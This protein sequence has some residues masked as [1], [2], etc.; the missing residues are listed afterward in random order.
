MKQYGIL[1]HPAK[2][3][4]SPVMHNAAFKELKIDAQ[5]GFFDVP[6]EELAKFM[7]Y[8]R[9]EP[10]SGLSVSL[11]HKEAVMQ[12]LDKISDDARKIGAVNTVVN[13]GGVLHGHNTDYIG[14]NVALLDKAVP[15]L[16]NKIVVVIGAGGSARA[17]VYG[18]LEEGA[19]VWIKNRT[20]EKADQIAIEFAEMFN[21]EVHSDDWDNWHTGDILV[22]ATS[23]WTK[24]PDMD[25]KDLPPFCDEDY[26][27]GFDAVMDV[28]YQ[29]LMTPLLKKAEQLGKKIVTGD[30]MLFFQAVK[31][32]EIFA[33]I[34]FKK[35]PID[36]MW[37]ALN[38]CL[39]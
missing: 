33:D 37:E 13:Q 11:P 38:K 24:H 22:H 9:H 3:S 30:N 16:K 34:P 15:K 2:H 7:D 21:T 17:I 27:N 18:L 23:L 6:E 28:C 36:A 4:L 12:Y 19:H 26:L 5:Y 20:K 29:P 10:I 39:P 32:F 35:V 14:S 8:V 25:E 31:Q 1:A